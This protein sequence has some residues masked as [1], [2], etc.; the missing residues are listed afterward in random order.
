MATIQ[1]VAA[2]A[3]V[4]PITVSRVLNNSGYVSQATRQRVEAAA[5]ALNYVPNSLASSLRSNR[6]N[7][8]ALLLADISNP[9]WTTVARG[10]ED[11]ANQHGY[12]VILCNTDEKE[13]KQEEYVALLLRK[14]VDGFLLVPTTA[15]TE[16]IRMIQQQQVPIVLVDRAIPDLAVDTVRGDTYGSAYTLANHLIALGHRRIAVLAGPCYIS[17]SAERVEAVCV[18]L[19]NAALPIDA[20]LILYGEYA[21]ESGYAMASQ[22]LAEQPT[23]IV[24]GN[25]FI[26]IGV[27]RFLQEAELRVPQ[28]ISVVCFDDVPISW[29]SEPFLTVAVQPAYEIGQRATELLLTRVSGK[30]LGPPQEHQ[31]PVEILIRRSTARLD[32]SHSFGITAKDR[33]NRPA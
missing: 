26:A 29:G 13:R 31:L 6:T 23:A 9:F 25:N 3:G 4:A 11:V 8:L 1:D 2:K 10:V 28:D 16:S 5:Q 18:A 14:R 17:T 19:R 33:L 30:E 21:V 15:A 20:K 32:A 22:V 7:I 24:A 12:S 27:G